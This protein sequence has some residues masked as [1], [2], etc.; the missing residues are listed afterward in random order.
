MGN[1]LHLACLSS[2]ED[3]SNVFLNGEMYACS[4]QTGLSLLSH[5][6]RLQPLP[7]TDPLTGARLAMPPSDPVFHP[8][9]RNHTVDP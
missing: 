7:F 8:F 1:P 6:A 4:S 5:G 3:R 2:H 9:Q